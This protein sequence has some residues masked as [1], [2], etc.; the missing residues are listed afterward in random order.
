MV[1]SLTIK[2]LISQY[3][4]LLKTQC[5]MQANRTLIPPKGFTTDFVKIKMA[6][7]MLQSQ[8]TKLSS[9]SPRS[10]R[11]RVEP[12]FDDPPFPC[13]IK[14]DKTQRTSPRLIYQQVFTRILDSTIEPTPVLV[15]ADLMLRIHMAPHFRMVTPSQHKLEILP[16][17]GPDHYIFNRLISHFQNPTTRIISLSLGRL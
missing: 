14:I 10:I 8:M 6:E 7:R 17:H 16:H 1:I 9:T 11:C 5:L 15:H 13:D 12:P 4:F 3:A 2:M